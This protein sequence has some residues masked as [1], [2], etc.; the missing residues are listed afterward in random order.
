MAKST[1]KDEAFKDLSLLD[2]VIA[3]KR[4]FY[5]CPWAKYEE[6][7]PGSIHL[8]PPAYH[9]QELE[10]DYQGMQSML[11]GDIPSFTEIMEGIAL[12]EMEINALRS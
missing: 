7:V 10:K 11:F 3:F 2:E 12:L 4:R 5:R 8:L 1:V 6:A 9:M